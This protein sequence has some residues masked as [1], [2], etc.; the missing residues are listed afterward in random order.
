[1]KKI[2]IKG[3][4]IRKKVVIS[5]CLFRY[6]TFFEYKTIAKKTC[7]PKTRATLAMPNILFGVC[8][9]LFVCCVSS[10]VDIFVPRLILNFD[11]FY[12]TVKCIRI[13]YLKSRKNFASWVLVPLKMGNMVFCLFLRPQEICQMLQ[14]GMHAPKYF[15]LG[16]RLLWTL[17]DTF[18]KLYI[19][20][21]STEHWNTNFP[22][23]FIYF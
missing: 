18:A 22:K 10:C 17:K 12:K 13:E 14:G 3:A 16:I 15:I 4:E 23:F 8:C 1:M 2:E 11:M 6:G 7:A 5:L 19:F 9:R 21:T 20:R